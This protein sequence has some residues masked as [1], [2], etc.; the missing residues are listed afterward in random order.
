MTADVNGLP[1]VSRSAAPKAPRKGGWFAVLK[2]YLAPILISCI[3][4]VGS[5]RYGAFE[6]NYGTLWAIVTAI[7]AET[8]LSLFVSGRLPHFASAYITGISVGILVRTPLVWPYV[9]CSLLSISSK[10]ALRVRN[11][12]LWNPSNLGV[13]ILLFIVPDAVAP[14]SQQLGN[15]IYVLMIIGAFGMLI[16]YTLGRLHITLTYIIA[17]VLLSFVRLGISRGDWTVVET[18]W[19]RDYIWDQWVPEVALLTSP[20]YLLFMFFM[21]TDP[22]T[23]PST[24]G[25][26]IAVTILVAIVETLFRIG[27]ELHA[28]YY[29]L[30]VVF[31]VTNL[32]EIIWEAMHPKPAKAVAVSPAAGPAINTGIVAAER[33]AS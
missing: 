7:L 24:K 17:F 15:E 32:A 28:P 1:T 33:P 4:V 27:R 10:Y 26:Q 13:S 11:R 12:H 8:A 29:A 14:L 6:G 9:M 30:F 19:T 23:T 20:A 22:K 21:I 18:M 31:P 5:I 25:R 2:P 3:F 16:L